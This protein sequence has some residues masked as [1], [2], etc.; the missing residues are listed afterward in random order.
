MLA[1]L[2]PS[3]AFVPREGGSGRVRH[4]GGSQEAFHEL[5]AG[6]TV[7][8]GGTTALCVTRGDAR[9]AA[10][11]VENVS[12]YRGPN[13]ILSDIH[14]RV[15]PQEK[16]GLVGGNGQGKST[17]LKAFTEE[18]AYDGDVTIMS[19]LDLGYLQQTAVSG[20]TK[21]V[22]DE[23]ASAMVEIQQARRDMEQAT[24]RVE[25]D[26][27]EK[28]LQALDVA[29]LKFE[30][31]GG[32]TQEK[33]V[34]SVLKGLGF[35]DLQQTCDSLSGGWQMRVSLAKL[36][37]SKPSLLLLDEPSN[38]LDVNARK[39]LA[40]YLTHYKEGA[41]ILVT[42]DVAL[43]SSVQHIAQ[44]QSGRL[45]VFKSCTYPQYLE[46]KDRRAAA[47]VA[48]YERNAQKAAK[49]QGFVDRFGA[50]A[51]KA[52]AAQ[53]RVK[54]LEKMQKQGLLDDPSTLVAG[55]N[56]FQPTLSLPDPPR[57][58]GECLIKLEGA[59]VGWTA[60]QP[61]VNNVNLSINKG[62][63]LWIRAPNGAGKSTLLAALRGNLEL[64]QGS[65]TTNQELK[66]GVF[67]QDLAQ[68]L[69]PT[70]RAVDLVTAH[71]RTDDISITDQMARSAMGRLGLSGDKPL[72]K[73]Q[74]L[75]GGEKA[76]VALAMF[77]LKPSN[78]LLLDE[79]SNH[80]DVECVKALSEALSDW[81]TDQGAIVVV[82]HDKNFCQA[83]GFSHV[84]TIHDGQ[85]SVQERAMR[86][87]DWNFESSATTPTMGV[88]V[89][90]R[91]GESSSGTG[92]SPQVDRSL[93][94]QVY[95][96]PKRIAK[97]E[98]LIEKTELS[99]AELES[100]MMAHGSDVGKLMDLTE[101]K[102]DLE[103]KVTEYMEEWESLEELLESVG[104]Q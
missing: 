62:M 78:C 93:K 23:A 55:A 46:E 8:F 86:D 36:L 47:A 7:K 3:R 96:A 14:W 17:L 103:N 77:C 84:G 69:D 51:T 64:F 63:K 72:R 98:T 13:N 79:P 53:S 82:S 42:H 32:Y 37:L 61:L 73:I 88:A 38:H 11:L 104:A 52:S 26:A 95:N 10:L 57:A 9:G 71:A 75:S 90:T 49:L 60:D 6:P 39:W 97:L 89:S 70:A 24:R 85:F 43:L 12:V 76:R 2:L 91:N 50:S 31:V 15:E 59:Q 74:D 41:M 100:E 44:V 20:S 18:L 21:T 48:E 66:L 83:V 101:Q 29:T 65:R 102:A 45:E 68:E 4:S 81:G 58:I 54:Q 92:A 67:T 80:L 33:E 94:K 27:S 30:A 99:I 28:N 56:N 40:T 19:T 16:W 34:S 25:E 22:F 87:S 1:L 35:S 5:T